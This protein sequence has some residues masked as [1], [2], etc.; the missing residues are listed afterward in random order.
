M[1]ID[2]NF[3]K[4]PIYNFVKI[5]ISLKAIDNIEYEVDEWYFTRLK[6]FFFFFFF[7]SAKDVIK[8]KFVIS[9]QIF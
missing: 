5:C 7:S 8:N 3:I 2:G 6:F 1:K 4:L 9:I